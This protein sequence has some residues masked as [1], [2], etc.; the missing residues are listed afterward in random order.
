MVTEHQGKHASQWP[1]ICSIAAKIGCSG[2]TLRQLATPASSCRFVTASG[3]AVPPADWFEGISRIRG[4]RYDYASI[5]LVGR[6]AEAAEQGEPLDPRQ[7]AEGI[8]KRR[9]TSRG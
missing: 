8:P 9:A 2:E 1:A 6:A 7:E 5:D 3:T 4:Y